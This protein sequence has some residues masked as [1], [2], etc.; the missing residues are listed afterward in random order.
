VTDDPVL[1][2]A[3]QIAPCIACEGTGLLRGEVGTACD[4]CD[5]KGHDLDIANL[6]AALNEARR[7]AVI[8][9]ERWRAHPAVLG[10]MLEGSIATFVRACEFHIAEEQAKPLPDNSLIATLCNAVRL[11]REH[12]NLARM[13]LGR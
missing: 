7:E 9:S 11:T 6:R 10:T 13:R 4:V 8:E 1:A 2:L 3:R 5:G 12:E